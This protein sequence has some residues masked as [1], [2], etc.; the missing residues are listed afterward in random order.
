MIHLF[1]SFG[2]NTEVADNTARIREALLLDT[3][4][5]LAAVSAINKKMNPAYAVTYRK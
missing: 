4:K 3:P 1:E 2:V 5:T